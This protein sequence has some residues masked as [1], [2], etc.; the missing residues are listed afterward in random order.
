MA[1][2]I[3]ARTILWAL[4]PFE[5]AIPAPARLIS[6]L[7]DSDAK[8]RI[9]PIY[10]LGTDGMGIPVPIA[11]EAMKRKLSRV[12]LRG[13]QAPK[14]L[15]FDGP[16]P[17]KA[18][19]A[20]LKYAKSRQADLIVVGTHSRKGLPRLFLGS[21]AETL[22]LRS[23]IPVLITHPEGKTSGL[24]Q[25]IVFPTDLSAGSRRLFRRALKLAKACRARLTIVHGIPH[26]IEPLIQS[27]V[28]LLGGG[29]D[30]SSQ[31]VTEAE[32]QARRALKSLVREASKAGVKTSCVLQPA[33]LPVRDVILAASRKSDVIAMGAQ[34]GSVA[35][36]LIG[37]ITRQVVREARCPVWVIR[38]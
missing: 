21:F 17:R 1:G 26:P 7:G 19:D 14:V 20:L 8:V 9:E 29:W 16:S 31:L 32:E 33:P 11:E 18:V 13:L 5:T 24:I 12:K 28:S 6:T 25:N 10:L 34:S 23:K 2:R 35:A 3:P 15:T 30:P 4:D 27:G 22:L 37:S 38:A 36:A